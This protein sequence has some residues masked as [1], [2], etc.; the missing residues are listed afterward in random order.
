MGAFAGA[1]VGIYF[2]GVIIAVWE[3][4]TGAAIGKM[5][6]GIKIKSADGSPASFGKRLLRSL[7]KYNAQV[8]GVVTVLTGVEAINSVGNI[9]LLVMAIGCLLV[10]GGEKQALHDKLAGTA[11]YPKDAKVDDGLEQIRENLE[12]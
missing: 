11:V 2:A 8:L 4:C 6:L 5:A 9:G 7:L 12:S 3:A 10:L 1:L